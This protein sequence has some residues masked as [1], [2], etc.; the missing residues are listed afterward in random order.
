MGCSAEVIN[1]Y[2]GQRN[3]NKYLIKQD[4]KLFQNEMTVNNNNAQKY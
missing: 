3:L 2:L 4:F 1:Q